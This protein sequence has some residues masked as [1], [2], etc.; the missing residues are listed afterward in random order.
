MMNVVGSFGSQPQMPITSHLH[1][2]FQ[3]LCCQLEPDERPT[4]REVEKR[5]SELLAT[6]D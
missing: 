1:L 5:V 4:I 2:P 3:L 6:I